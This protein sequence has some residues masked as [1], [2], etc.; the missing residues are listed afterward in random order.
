MPNRTWRAL[1][2][3]ITIWLGG[4]GLIAWLG[5][6]RYFAAAVIPAAFAALPLMVGLTPFHLRDVP[7]DQ[8]AWAAIRFGV[9]VTAVQFP[10]DTL[11]WLAIFRLRFPPHTAA[12]REATIFRSS[13][14]ESRS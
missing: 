8:R 9:V 14:V 4:M 2:I 1:A 13:S 7:A 5:E 6:T 3:G 11:G 10:L 12:A